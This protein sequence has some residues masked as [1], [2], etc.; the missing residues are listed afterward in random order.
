MRLT[1]EL[2]VRASRAEVWAAVSTMD[3][4]NQEV[5]PFLRMTDPTH[6]AHFDAE[7]WRTSAPVLW[8]LVFGVIPVE[9]QR[10]C[11]CPIRSSGG[12]S[13]GC[14]AGDIVSC[15]AGSGDDLEA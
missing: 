9:I 5:A 12:R 15:V 4:I 2:P 7:P 1:V 3:G 10:D 6:S 11:G 13:A 8:Q 14:S